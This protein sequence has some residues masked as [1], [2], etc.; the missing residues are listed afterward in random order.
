MGAVEPVGGGVAG[1]GAFD[2]CGAPGTLGAIGAGGEI[3]PGDGGATPIIVAFAIDFGQGP[4]PG[5]PP[6]GAAGLDAA[7]GEFIMS[8]VPLN[9]GA[10]APLRLKPHFWHFMPLS[11]F[12]VPQFGQNTHLPPLDGIAVLL[13]GADG[14]YIA[15]ACCSSELG[16]SLALFLTKCRNKRPDIQDKCPELLPN[17]MSLPPSRV[18]RVDL[19]GAIGDHYRSLASCAAI[20][21]GRSTTCARR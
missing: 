2:E 19:T 15:R 5:T 12:C 14:A 7:I 10:A 18:G 8:I 16:L 13:G 6:G 21:T 20:Q 17:C 11:S 3:A 9:L 4:G 1:R